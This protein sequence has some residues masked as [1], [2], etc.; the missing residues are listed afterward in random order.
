MRTLTPGLLAATILLSASAATA[1]TAEEVVA[2]HIAAIGGKEKIAQIKS[3]YMEN[4][5]DVMGNE[6]PGTTI[7][8]NG[9]GFR[10]EVDFNGQKI[11]QVVTDKDGWSINPMAGQ[12]TA[13]P[14]PADQVQAAQDQLSVGGPLLNYTEKGGKIELAGK[15]N[16][17][18]VDA[19]KL[20]ITGKDKSESTYFLDPASY[21]VLK[22]VHKQSIGGQAME[23]TS[24]FSNYQKT[25][26]GYVVPFTTE[27]QLPQFTLKYTTKKIEVNKPVDETIFKAG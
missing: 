26:Y 6:A 2:K 13:T 17:N 3:I 18:G 5:I 11:V 9:K 27:M 16:L 14:M 4:S 22:S 23:V 24:L 25:D 7:I 10:N 8:L 19:I 1:Q 20:K 15:E 12:T 21:Y